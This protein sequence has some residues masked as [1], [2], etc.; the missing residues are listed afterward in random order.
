MKKG[1]LVFT[2]F[3]TMLKIGLFTFGGGYGM[4]ALL[5]NEFVA[6]RKWISKEEFLDMIAIAESSPGPIAI[7]SSTYIGYKM[8]KFWGSL[9][10]TI[11]VCIPSFVIIFVISLFLDS[12]LALEFVG[13][14]FRGIQVGVS[15]LIFNAG[16]KMLKDVKKKPLPII[17]LATTIVCM[18]CFSIFAIK[19]SSIFYI[20]IGGVLG[21]FVYHIGNICAKQKNKH[22]ELS[23]K[24]ENQGIDKPKAN[25]DKESLQTIEKELK[26]ETKEFENIL[27]TMEQNNKDK[28]SKWQS[29]VS[30]LVDKAPN[31]KK[32]GKK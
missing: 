11:G 28:I 16:I 26:Q 5:E 9:A 1:K 13:Y 8:A 19:F 4:I 24:Q 25:L 7:N 3:Y 30:T 21:L 22:L 6:K 18:V 31:K 14:A 17:I 27:L 12:F 32:G 15:F 20:I 10:A 2:L 23:L 29:K